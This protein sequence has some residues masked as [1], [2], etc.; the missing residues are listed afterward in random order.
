[1]DWKYLGTDLHGR[2]IK[3][4]AFE[5]AVA[6]MVENED[7]TTEQV[8]LTKLALLKLIEMRPISE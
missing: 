1:M 3:A 8:S 7:G 6:V 4:R 5:K 2:P